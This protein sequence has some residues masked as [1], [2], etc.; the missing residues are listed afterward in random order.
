EDRHAND[1]EY[2]KQELLD[3]VEHSLS[4]YQY[5]SRNNIPESMMDIRSA[6]ERMQN[7]KVEVTSHN[8]SF[9]VTTDISPVKTTIL[10]SDFL[11][12]KEN[13]IQIN[14]ECKMKY[15][16]LLM[17]RDYLYRDIEVNVV[18]SK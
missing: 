14:W 5:M 13:D 17:F 6:E 3:D 18:E 8:H 11:P 16:N 1:S 15:S 4:F 9:L 10:S 12:I 2:K 7:E